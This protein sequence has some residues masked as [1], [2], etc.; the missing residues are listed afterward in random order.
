MILDDLGG[1]ADFWY[2]LARDHADGA[3]VRLAVTPPS[4][5]KG[6]EVEFRVVQRF[7][8]PSGTN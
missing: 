7:V 4:K 1:D 3:I 6:N 8:S 2:F 5:C